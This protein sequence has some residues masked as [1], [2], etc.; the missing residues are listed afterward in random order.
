MCL[1]TI[2]RDGGETVRESIMSWEVGANRRGAPG[3][4]YTTFY[5]RSGLSLFQQD[6]HMDLLIQMVGT[7]SRED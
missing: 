1:C 7:R 4:P 6:I 5:A 2:C 3:G